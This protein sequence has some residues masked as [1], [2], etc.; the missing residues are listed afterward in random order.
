MSL[1]CAGEKGGKISWSSIKERR[2]R[3]FKWANR[4]VVVVQ[5][6]T[7]TKCSAVVCSKECGDLLREKQKK[8]K[9]KDEGNESIMEFPFCLYDSLGSLQ[10]PHT[11]CD[12]HWQNMFYLTHYIVTEGLNVAVYRQVISVYL[13]R[14]SK[15]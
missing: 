9:K 7:V 11:K 2:R 3:P 10:S 13:H 4:V 5:R 6:L 12:R 8:K 14:C 1:R 15:H